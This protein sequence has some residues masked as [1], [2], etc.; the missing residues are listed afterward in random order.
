MQFVQSVSFVCLNSISNDKEIECFTDMRSSLALVV[1]IL[2]RNRGIS[3]V[4]CQFR[5]HWAKKSSDSCIHSDY[6]RI[7]SD[8]IWHELVNEY[9]NLRKINRYL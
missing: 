3:L 4:I 8:K 1:S 7:D 9:V 6:Q 5:H 2:Q